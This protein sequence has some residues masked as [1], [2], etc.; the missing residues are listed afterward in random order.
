MFDSNDLISQEQHDQMVAN[1]QYLVGDELERLIK[2]WNRS[3]VDGA[4]PV[5]I[6]QTWHPHSVETYRADVAHMDECEDCR[7]GIVY[8]TKD[9]EWER[10]CGYEFQSQEFIDDDWD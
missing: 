5:M 2:G 4:K 7:E 8:F 10:L 6:G 9:G 1:Y 3:I